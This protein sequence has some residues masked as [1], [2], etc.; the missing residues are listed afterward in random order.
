MKTV[1]LLLA[2]VALARSAGACDHPQPQPQPYSFPYLPPT[3][4][5]PPPSSRKTQLDQAVSEINSS[6]GMLNSMLRVV[7]VK[8]G[9]RY[10]LSELIL[11]SVRG[12][13][14]ARSLSVGFTKLAVGR[15]SDRLDKVGPA[16][17]KAFIADSALLALQLSDV[18]AALMR[19]EQI[20]ALADDEGSE[21]QRQALE[22]EVG[23]IVQTLT[24]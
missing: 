23:R 18:R 1:I 11:P 17:G 19:Y 2:A 15:L 9:G 8:T 22:F 21:L 24:K 20:R 14:P 6:V 16:I 12:D 10:R 4:P 5:D 13:E 7:D 3:L